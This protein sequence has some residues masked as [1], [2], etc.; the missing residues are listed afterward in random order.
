MILTV[1]RNDVQVFCRM[2]FDWDSSEC[3]SYDYS[4]VIGFGEKDDRYKVPFSSCRIKG[5]HHQREL[6]LWMVT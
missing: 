1:L 4:G 2:S 5:T 6:P 3:F